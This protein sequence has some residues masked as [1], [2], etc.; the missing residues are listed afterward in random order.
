MGDEAE[1]GG[2]APA[3]PEEPWAAAVALEAASAAGTRGAS[4]EAPSSGLTESGLTASEVVRGWS[5]EAASRGT[6]DTHASAAAVVPPQGVS[7]GTPRLSETVSGAV[8]GVQEAAKQGVATPQSR[9][10]GT[11]SAP[12]LLGSVDGVGS[13]PAG[14]QL[15]AWVAR[16]P[17]YSVQAQQQG[18]AWHVPLPREGEGEGAEAVVAEGGRGARQ[19]VRIVTDAQVAAEVGAEVEAAE[20]EAAAAA[21]EMRAAA[22]AEAAA[23]A[24]K[25][26]AQVPWQLTKR[27]GELSEAR[28]RELLLAAATSYPEFAE[29]VM[30]R[31]EDAAAAA[32]E[33]DAVADDL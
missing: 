18:N 28:C 31:E 32:A 12:P 6:F 33:R 4:A 24:A 5:S 23:A 29:L 13:G 7:G 16:V 21:A 2:E 15:R 25:R 19:W 8:S 27:V 20:A 10:V 3:Q 22:V 11:A 17:R 9:G 1:A 30:E 14:T 26:K